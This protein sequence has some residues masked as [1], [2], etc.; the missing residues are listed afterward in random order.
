MSFHFH[1]Q[2]EDFMNVPPARID[3]GQSVRHGSLTVFPLL[4][5]VCNPVDYLLSDEAIESGATTVS[6][7]SDQGSVPDLIVTNKGARRVLFLEGEELRGAKQ[8]RILN[9]TVLV[10]AQTTLKIPVSCVEQGRWSKTSA[11]LMAGKTL[12]SYKLR[13]V[14]KGSLLQSLRLSRG[15][16]SDQGSVWRAVQAQQDT[17]GVSSATTAMADSF[18]GYAT[19]IN[20]A[21]SSLPYVPEASGMAVAV[22]G[23]VVSVDLFDKPATCR[24]VWN[25]LLSG[26]LLDALAG[27]D[28]T[29]GPPEPGQVVQMLEE[30]RKAVW[31]K[32]QAVGEGQEY[33]AEYSGKMGS[34]L[35]LA[36][37]LVHGSVVA[38]G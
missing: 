28:Q 33:R 1:P 3:I 11:F 38:A 24:K 9:T 20:D 31:T 26:A 22:G 5:T 6:E 4:C 36:G 10:A 19:Q 37:A 25:R 2:E 15:H 17:L 21:C 32:T 16:R 18:A 7:V 34:A 29:D 12:P 23:Q 8:N 13:S 35:L 14:L 27:R 30:T